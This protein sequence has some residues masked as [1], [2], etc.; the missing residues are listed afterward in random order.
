MG[1]FARGGVSNRRCQDLIGARTVRR[2]KREVI[3]SETAHLPNEMPAFITVPSLV[4]LEGPLVG[5]S[6]DLDEPVVSIGREASNDI[7]LDDPYVSRHHCV[8]KN[9]GQAYL[10]EDLASANGTY[11]DGARVGTGTLKEG[12]LIDIGSS[13]FLFRLRE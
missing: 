9:D 11:L 5:R 1:A 10:I 13:R 4:A 12:S 7:R 2:R 6:I 3:S 8:I